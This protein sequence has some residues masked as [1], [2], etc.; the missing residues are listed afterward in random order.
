[1]VEIS[2]VEPKADSYTIAIR[3]KISRQYKATLDEAYEAI[4]HSRKDKDARY[5]RH[6][7]TRA[8]KG[9]RQIFLDV[10]RLANDAAASVL[11]LGA[12]PDFKKE[13]SKFGSIKDARELCELADST[14]DIRRAAG[15]LKDV[16]AAARPRRALEELEGQVLHY[17]DARFRHLVSLA[18][19]GEINLSEKIDSGGAYRIGGSKLDSHPEAERKIRKHIRENRPTLERLGFL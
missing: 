19:G 3:Q 6:L 14:R 16:Q 1:M 7:N 10:K 4:R 11:V 17:V 18:T 12:L 9:A 2:R 15:R 5:R 8:S 13:V